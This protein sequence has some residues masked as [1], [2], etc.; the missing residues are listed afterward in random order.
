MS[1]D[2]TNDKQPDIDKGV[3]QAADSAPTKAAA[4][5]AADR[6]ADNVPTVQPED[7]VTGTQGAAPDG[8]SDGVSAGNP[9]EVLLES[10]GSDVDDSGNADDSSNAEGSSDGASGKANSADVGAG[11][12]TSAGAAQ[13]VAAT[14]I[15]TGRPLA[16][17]ALLMSLLALAASAAAGWLYFQYQQG[18]D[19]F[20]QAQSGQVDAIADSVDGQFEKIDALQRR[21]GVA[22]ESLASETRERSVLAEG[23]TAQ[24]SALE[25]KAQSHARRILAMTATT[26][27]DWRVAEVD[28]LLR[29]ANQRLMI[30]SDSETA[31]SL[32]ETADG[33]LLELA[34]P[35]LTAAREAI[36]DDRALLLV[37]D[38]DVDGVFLALSAISKNINALPV[39]S[40]PTFETVRDKFGESENAD[41]DAESQTDA[42]TDAADQD[43]AIP[44]FIKAIGSVFVRGWKEIQSWMII[45]RPDAAVKP[46]L[47]PEQQYYLR[48]N[49]RM[50]INQAQIS[51]LEQRQAPYQD[52]LQNAIEWLVDYFPQSESAVQNLIAELEQ[53][54][55]LDIDPDYPDLS[56]SLLQIK[57]FINSQLEPQVRDDVQAEKS[58]DPNERG[59]EEQSQEDA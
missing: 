32:I 20:A 39:V 17:L 35:R 37:A 55:A 34:D 22:E 29:L 59:V 13:P 33:I 38:L 10:Y 57:G 52:S 54:A 4:G 44:G 30:S 56:N 3:D 2:K 7:G 8:D 49:L 45:N 43:D 28:Y 40:A 9:E 12:D 15:K 19:K 26:T 6:T 48:N 58:E 47:P 1:E 23:V 11:T 21:L 31:L 25:A 53:L 42:S 50:L 41:G 16:L 24:L 27:D 18:S 51:L 5:R 36:A 14:A 46:L